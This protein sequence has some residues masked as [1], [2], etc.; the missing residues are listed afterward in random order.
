MKYKSK[1]DL[2]A[3]VGREHDALIALV[4]IVPASRLDEAGVWGD[5]WSV[6]DLLA[7]LSEWHSLFLGWFRDGL[8][9]ASPELPAPGYKWNETPRLKRAIWAKHAGRELSS[10]AAEFESTYEELLHLLEKLSESE[11]LESGHFAWTGRNPLVTY[12]GA[13]TASHYRFAQRVL[14]RWMKRPGAVSE[15]GPVVDGTRTATQPGF[16]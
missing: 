16:E 14:K 11:L 8:R 15:A 5:D 3:Q 6:C 4:G 1:V 10:I 13:N 12:A 2:L 9:G 7:H